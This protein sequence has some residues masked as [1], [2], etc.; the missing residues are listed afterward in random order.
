MPSPRPITNTLTLLPSQ[1]L[2]RRRRPLLLE[3]VVTRPKCIQAAGKLHSKTKESLYKPFSAEIVL[4]TESTVSKH[5]SLNHYSYTVHIT[6][7][8]VS[9]WILR[10]SV[11]NEHFWSLRWYPQNHQHNKSSCSMLMGKYS[12]ITS[13]SP[14]NSLHFLTIF[15]FHAGLRIY[16]RSGMYELWKFTFM[17]YYGTYMK[18]FTQMSWSSEFYMYSLTEVNSYPYETEMQHLNPLHFWAFC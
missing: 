3:T 14:N 17:V 5:K 4:A 2:D 10:C 11:S 12:I 9:T 8:Q 15:I 16:C 18:I 7:S 13:H 6:A 1:M